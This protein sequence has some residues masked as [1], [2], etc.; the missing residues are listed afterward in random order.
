MSVFGVMLL[1]LAGNSHHIFQAMIPQEG[2][3]LAAKAITQR[4]KASSQQEWLASRFQQRPRETD[5]GVAHQAVTRRVVVTLV[6]SI[7]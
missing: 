4:P 6:L 2:E 3:A 5:E 7:K 1:L